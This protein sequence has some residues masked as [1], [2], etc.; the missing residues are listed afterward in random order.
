[1]LSA[2]FPDINPSFHLAIV[3]GI[4]KAGQSSFTPFPMSEYH[5]STLTP[6]AAATLL[7][8]PTASSSLDDEALMDMII[9]L[10]DHPAQDN[11][12]T[13]LHDEHTEMSPAMEP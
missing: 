10:Q 4:T 5:T 1:M 9:D 6:T 11:P 3:G 13:P 7:S 12:G 2:A 8:H